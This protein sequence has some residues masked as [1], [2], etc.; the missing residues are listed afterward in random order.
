VGDWQD[1]PYGVRP[2]DVL[3]AVSPWAGNVIFRRTGK[4]V[5]VTMN[6]TRSAITL[7]AEWTVVT[8]IPAE[9]T[10][11]GTVYMQV[12]WNTTTSPDALEANSV[13]LRHNAAAT[14][15]QV[16]S[17]MQSTVVMRGSW[18]YFAA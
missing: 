11:A 5:S 3:S 17:R 8:G 6:I 14:S 12:A 7:N 18:S 13:E 10:P 16:L 9:Y 1:V 4:H 2:P 15:I